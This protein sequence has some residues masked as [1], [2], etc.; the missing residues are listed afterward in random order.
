MEISEGTRPS[1]SVFIVN[2]NTRALLEQCLESII[3]TKNG[4]SVEVFVADNN[5]TDGSAKM[6]R[7][8][9]PDVSL[10]RYPQNVGYTKAVNPLLHCASGQYCLLLHPDLQLLPNTLKEFVSFFESH[11]SA[12]I[13]GGNLYYPDGSPNPCEILWPGLRNDLLCSA[14]R[15]V[16]KIPK[17]AA[18]LRNYNPMEWSHESTSQVPAVWN[19]CMMV[20][21]EV[22]DQVGYFDEN[23]FVWAAD[24]D[25]CKRAADSGWN[26]YYLYP[27][28]AIHHER[29]SFSIDDDSIRDEVRYKVD[30]WYSAPGQIGDRY[31]FLRKHADP[32][33]VSGVKVIYLTENILRLHLIMARFMFQ[34]DNLNVMKF[35]LGACVQ[36][37]RAIL[38]A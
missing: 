35:Q 33:S 30:G 5:S 4:L 37:I 14:V 24:W 8:R 1:V 6:V 20:R 9:F 2:Y 18:L 21:R 25:L 12:G 38:K 11:P 26:V 17:G 28:K 36:T 10:R 7:A 32:V 34:R 19:A 23:F 22:F 31:T 16:G 13:L 15:L 29:Q 3:E 27:A